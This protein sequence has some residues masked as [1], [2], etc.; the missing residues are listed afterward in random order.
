MRI[1]TLLCGTAVAALVTGP[2]SAQELNIY[3]WADELPAEIVADFEA[4]TGIT[5]TLDTFDSNESLVAKLAAGASGYDLI[6]P[7]QYA[8]QILIKQNL[9]V[10]LDHA[11]LPNLKNVDTAYLAKALDQIAVAA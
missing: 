6:E 10:P 7:S 11:K 2:A 4:E 9:I 5:V 3:A 1:Q 8:V